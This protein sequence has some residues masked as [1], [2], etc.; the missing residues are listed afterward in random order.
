MQAPAGLHGIVVKPLEGHSL[1]SLNCT[2]RTIWWGP[3]AA[4]GN[5]STCGWDSGLCRVALDMGGASQL[6]PAPAAAGFGADCAGV[7]QLRLLQAG[8][9]TSAPVHRRA[10][11]LPRQPCCA[12]F[13]LRTAHRT[14]GIHYPSV[15]LGVPG[16]HQC[17]HHRCRARPRSL[18]RA[19]QPAKHR[20]HLR[21]APNRPR[22]LA[23]APGAGQRAGCAALAGC[24]QGDNRM[25][26]ALQ[27]IQQQL[28]HDQPIARSPP[29][30]TPPLHPVCSFILSLCALSSFPPPFPLTS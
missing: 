15:K 5:P 12:C 8:G 16:Q 24:K 30:P 1:G 3:P 22:C 9:G 20:P 6:G 18:Q 13:A 2:G 7:L 23:A 19:R 10:A 4:W 26:P 14:C 28:Q 21:A 25:V 17:Q 11:R 27:G 29:Y